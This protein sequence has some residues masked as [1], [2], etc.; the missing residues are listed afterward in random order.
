MTNERTIRE[1]IAAEI[2]K[3]ERF[4]ALSSFAMNVGRA[5]AARGI[6]E[7]EVV[8]PDGEVLRYLREEGHISEETYSDQVGARDAALLLGGVFKSR[9][10]FRKDRDFDYGQIVRNAFEAEF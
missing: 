5:H 10:F 2:A 9:V 6:G 8:L 3:A 7:W 1:S 4:I